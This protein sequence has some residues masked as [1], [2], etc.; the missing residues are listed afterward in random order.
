M[1]ALHGNQPGRIQQ[2][3]IQISVHPVQGSMWEEK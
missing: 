1:Q 3:T 2:H